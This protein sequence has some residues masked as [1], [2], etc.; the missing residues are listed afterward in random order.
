M[1]LIKKRNQT[2]LFSV[3]YSFLLQY[4][5]F[6]YSLLLL[7]LF[8]YWFHSI[9]LVGYPCGV[10]VNVLESKIIVSEF[11]LKLHYYFHFRTNTLGK[12]MEPLILPAMD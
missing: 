2:T 12:G 6:I 10:M 8:Y 7:Q 11:E 4:F 3:D 1:P 9:F 5:H